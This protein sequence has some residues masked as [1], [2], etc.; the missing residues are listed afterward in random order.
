M[1]DGNLCTCI[2]CVWKISKRKTNNRHY[3][4][5]GQAQNSHA[6]YVRTVT[7]LKNV[8]IEDGR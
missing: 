7:P 1:Y 4:C 2:M 6:H 3:T 5:L 8:D